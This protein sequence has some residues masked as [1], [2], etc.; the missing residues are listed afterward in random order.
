MKPFRNQHPVRTFAKQY[1]NYRDYKKYLRS[2]FHR[3]CGY[4]NDLDTLCGGMRG[5]HIDHFCPQTV[6]RDLVNDYNNLVYACPYCNVAKSN[7]W[8]TGRPDCS[9]INNSGYVDPCDL[10]FDDHLE[11][12]D[13]GRIRPKTE[14]G[15]YMFQEL[16]LGLRRHQLAW[17][18]EQLEEL[19]KELTNELIK[20]ETVLPEFEALRKHHI[21]L[22]KEYLAYKT[23]FEETL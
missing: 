2:D 13:N 14:L 5:F 1:A 10:A 17:A 16:K 12:Y 22:T 3:R 9:V 4:C 15:R 8:P 6:A 11:R 7:D 23:L 18:Y 21:M 19:L 20:F